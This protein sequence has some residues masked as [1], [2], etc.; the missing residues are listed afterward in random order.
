LTAPRLAS[1]AGAVVVVAVLL[2]SLSW[3]TFRG[4]DGS[5]PP[6]MGQGADE[7]LGRRLLRTVELG[8]PQGLDVE[9][10]R[11][12]ADDANGD[13]ASVILARSALLV[14]H[15]DN[16]A[17]RIGY[18]E[19]LDRVLNNLARQGSTYPLAPDLPEAQGKTLALIMVY[20]MVMSGNQ[21]RAI[22]LL[23][24]HLSTGSAY[25]QAVALQAL[26]NIGTP[27]AIGL[28]QKYAETGQDKNLAQTTLADEDYPVLAELHDR[29]TLVPPKE[30]RRDRLVAIVESEGGCSERGAM[31]AY[32]LG[33]FPPH[34]DAERER[35]EL[36]ALKAMIRRSTGFCE[37]IGHIIALKSLALRSAE[38]VEYWAGLARETENVWERHQVVIDG[39]GRWGRQFAPAAL[40]LLKTEPTQYVQWELMQGSLET[41]Q[42]HRY[43]DIWELWL[44]VNILV[45]LQEGDDGAAR[46]EKPAMAT[47]LTWLE[48]GARP[49]DPW[50]ANHMIYNLAR[51]VSGDDTRRLLALFNAH[52]ARNQN[53]WIVSELPD[54]GA[55]P[56]LRYWASLPASQDQSAMLKGTIDRLQSDERSSRASGAACCAPT[57]AC[58]VEWLARPGPAAPIRSEDEARAWLAGNLTGGGYTVQYRDALERLAVVRREDG[59]E[60][61]WEYLYDCWR[62]LTHPTTGTLQ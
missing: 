2:A 4:D 33:F 40:D 26:R 38:S 15:R 32:W 7:A 55:L 22:D 10:I 48:S 44:P 45:L 6:D 30:R 49:R 41:L 16:D 47:L 3:W 60:E 17:R 14:L 35:Q 59:S 34:A 54:P 11:Q 12:I 61:Q 56:L 25:K 24:K 50:V 36:D 58:L 20:A 42:G 21:D 28:I 53:W 57:R 1:I 9:A 37:M 29:W 5:V 39:F 23:E 13:Y 43:R 51:W 19:L 18:Q 8:V 62:N 52:A 27:K 31:A 46:M